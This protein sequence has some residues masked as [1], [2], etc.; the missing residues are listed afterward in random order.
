MW[1]EVLLFSQKNETMHKKSRIYWRMYR[2]LVL[3]YIKHKETLLK[4]MLMGIFNKVAIR[5]KRA[6]EFMPT[7]WRRYFRPNFQILKWQNKKKLWNSQ[8]NRQTIRSNLPN[9][10]ML[11]LI[12]NKILSL[13]TY[14]K[15][16]IKR[17]SSKLKASIRLNCC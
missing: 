2:S 9:G 3:E 1:T 5:Y 17:S 8:R 7:M 16:L 15:A 4:T 14:I 10:P 11:F 13:A 12:L 6:I